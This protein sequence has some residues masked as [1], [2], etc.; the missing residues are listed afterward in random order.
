M[1]VC[2]CV[3][4]CLSVY[5]SESELILL[6]LGPKGTLRHKGIHNNKQWHNR[7]TAMYKIMERT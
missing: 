7:M 4:V 3:C 1:C 2:V 5:E 6:L